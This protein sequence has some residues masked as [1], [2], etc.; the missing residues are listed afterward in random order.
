M[1]ASVITLAVGAWLLTFDVHAD[2]GQRFDG[3]TSAEPAFCGSAYDVALLKGDGYMGGEYPSNQ[4]EI[5]SQCVVKAGRLTVGGACAFLTGLVA[6]WQ[7]TSALDRTNSRL[8]EQ[9]GPRILDEPSGAPAS[10]S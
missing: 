1:A 9:A 4:D 10:Y 6:L 7:C 8:A 3:Q 5:D 2:E